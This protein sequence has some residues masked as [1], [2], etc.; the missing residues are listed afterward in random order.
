LKAESI[1][2]DALIAYAYDVQPP[3]IVDLKSGPSLYDVEGKADGA[4][5]PAESRMS[6][7]LVSGEM[8]LSLMLLTGAGFMIRSFLNIYNADV[9]INRDLS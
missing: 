2:I 3:Q 6:G 9:G 1:S 8:A 5:S 7:F 4:Y